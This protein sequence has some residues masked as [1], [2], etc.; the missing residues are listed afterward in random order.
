MTVAA[1]SGLVPGAACARHPQR[2]AT[3]VCARCGDYLCGL[4]GRGVEG[5]LYCVPCAERLSSEHGRRA[6]HALAVGLASVHLL[7]FLGPVAIALGGLELWEIRAGKSA[8]GGR[9]MALA[10]VLLGSASL[11]M[12][13]GAAALVLFWR[14]S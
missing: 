9:G 6:V 11:L 7:F 13:A 12:A 1:S 5:R 10:G 8:Q 3:G 14:A 4:C 2:V